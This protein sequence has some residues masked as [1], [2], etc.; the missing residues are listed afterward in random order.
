MPWSSS[1]SPFEKE[2]TRG[3]SLEAQLDAGK[4]SIMERQKQKILGQGQ[5]FFEEQST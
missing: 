2:G 1:V 3:I 4:V 5:G